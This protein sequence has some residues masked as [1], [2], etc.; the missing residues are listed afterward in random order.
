MLIL[1]EILPLYNENY[2]ECWG[3][4]SYKDKTVLDL[5][6]DY[7]STAYYFLK[8]G[9][10]KVIA[11]EGDKSF[12]LRLAQNYGKNSRVVCIL[13]WISCSK[14]IEELVKLYPSD[15]VKVDIEGA[16]IYIAEVPSE[17][18][19]SVKEWLI[20]THTEEIYN[21]LSKLFLSL[22]FKVYAIDYGIKGVFRILLCESN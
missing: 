11:V 16:E 21:E 9:A 14:D 6:A 5:G 3:Y 8:K 2:D 20:E 12:S 1:K 10:I 13:K 4:V 17:V 15:I 22:G 7:G 19:L 18:L